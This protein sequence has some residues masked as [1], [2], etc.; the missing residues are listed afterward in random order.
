MIPNFFS[1][2]SLPKIQATNPVLIL[3]SCSFLG[4]IAGLSFAPTNFWPAILF[5]QLGLLY[6]LQP[7]RYV[8]T[9]LGLWAFWAFHFG[10][11]MYWMYIGLGKLLGLGAYTAV[12]LTIVTGIIYSAT[13]LLP[14]LLYC[15]C[16]PNSRARLACFPLA[17]VLCEW[18][19]YWILGGLTWLLT[20][21]TSHS[22]WLS[23]WIPVF[24]VM[25]ASLAVCLS[26]ILLFVSIQGRRRILPL[27][28]VT[29]IWIAGGFLTTV[30]WTQA[31]D[32]S[33]PVTIVQPEAKIWLQQSYSSEERDQLWNQEMAELSTSY[34]QPGLLIWPERGLRASVNHSVERLE[35]LA[36]QA[37]KSDT[38]LI[39]GGNYYEAQDANDF[40]VYNSIY[41]L[42]AADGLYFK[43]KLAPLGE[44]D[45][46]EGFLG[47]F[48]EDEK[49]LSIK[50][51]T[52]ESKLIQFD[53]QGDNFS[54][55]SLICYEIAWGNYLNSYAENA[56]ILVN[57][58]NDRWFYSSP[59]LEQTLQIAQIRAMEQQKPL[60]R[61]SFGGYSAHIN[62]R[63]KIIARASDTSA[64]T[65]S[66]SV[67]PRT[68]QT[69]Y[70]RFGDLP[71][72]L[73]ALLIWLG[74][75]ASIKIRRP[76]TS[77]NPATTDQ[78]A[79]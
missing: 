40:Q 11:A 50:A 62:Y 4:V 17:W 71:I 42:G 18:F 19:R 52:P 59:Q 79:D 33:I 13:L 6:L 26:A 57:L 44:R 36:L 58:S 49:R 63:G 75:L 10:T 38:A 56:Q 21:Y 72:L 2:F 3:A 8:I 65:I 22:I 48:S 23:G 66:T 27:A 78:A 47:L 68:G 43:E 67:K 60:L 16:P 5:A 46:L 1:G 29:L 51:T 74:S 30:N 73:I 45:L 34:W 55:A 41:G 61:S 31:L 76:N 28:G 69:P 77:K 25:G 9:L 39:T 70:S 53:Y 32:T 15:A 14:W 7:G 35:N 37:D 12:F 54:I 20:G 64:Q 24:G